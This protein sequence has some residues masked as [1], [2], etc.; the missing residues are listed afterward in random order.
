MVLILGGCKTTPQLV[1]THNAPYEIEGIDYS[2]TGSAVLKVGILPMLVEVQGNRDPNLHRL[3][4][5]KSAY[6]KVPAGKCTLVVRAAKPGWSSTESE[7]ISYYFQDGASYTLETYGKHESEESGVFKYVISRR[8]IRSDWGTYIYG[9][10]V[11]IP[12]S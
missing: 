10:D 3:T 2:Q 12:G 8:G 6:I 7:T 1:T 5:N 9:R 11:E 4:Y